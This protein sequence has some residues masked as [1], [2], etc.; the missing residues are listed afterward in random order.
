MSHTTQELKHE[1]KKS[2]ELL[3]RL[4]DEI[5]LK[6]HLAGMDAKDQWNR[7]LT[8]LEEVEQAAEKTTSET[9]RHALDEAIKKLQKFRDALQS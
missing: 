8:Q 5:G 3:Q 1:M 4:R 7:I 9:T 6:I 2:V